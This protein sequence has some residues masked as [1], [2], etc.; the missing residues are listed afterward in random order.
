MELVN[1][2]SDE[3]LEMYRKGKLN[4]RKTGQFV[5][6]DTQCRTTEESETLEYVL[7]LKVGV[8]V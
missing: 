2:Y 5:C 8:A 3:A 4:K 7:R 1:P 6:A